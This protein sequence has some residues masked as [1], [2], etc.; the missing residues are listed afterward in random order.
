VIKRIGTLKWAAD[1]GSRTIARNESPE[2]SVPRLL[3]RRPSR[4][5][6]SIE[7]PRAAAQEAEPSASS[8]TRTHDLAERG[9]VEDGATGRGKLRGAVRFSALLRR[10]SF[11]QPG[12]RAER[13]HTRRGFPV[14]SWR[15]SAEPQRGRQGAWSDVGHRI[16]WLG[17]ENDAY[18]QATRQARQGSMKGP[19]LFRLGEPLPLAGSLYSTD[20]SQWT[21]ARSTCNCRPGKRGG[22]LLCNA[23]R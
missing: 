4:R 9:G 12:S 5:P 18:V 22:L 16:G 3:W 23:D 7:A 11:A 10:S 6:R 1:K 13:L 14:R 19:A 2:G 17:V 15:R 21:G 20:S 8:S